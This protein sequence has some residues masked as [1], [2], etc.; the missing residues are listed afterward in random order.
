ME[1]VC[2]DEFFILLVFSEYI[3]LYDIR[4]LGD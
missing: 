3:E 4:K 2:I 1:R